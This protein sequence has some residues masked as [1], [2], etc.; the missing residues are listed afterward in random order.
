VTTGLTGTFFIGS[1]FV[2]FHNQPYYD[3]FSDHVPLGQPMLEFAESH[4]WD[5]LTTQQAIDST[6]NA[7]ISA[8]R[9]VV[10][11]INRTPSAHDAA[12][13]TRRAAEKGAEDVK[14]VAVDIF[15]K[16]KSRVESVGTHAKADVQKEAERIPQLIVVRPPKVS[17]DLA[18]L[19]EKVEH[20]LAGRLPTELASHVSKPITTPTEETS[21]AVKT[22]SAPQEPATRK[23]EGKHV[24]EAP[25][26]VG[27]EPPPGFS[28]PS[29]PKRATQEPAKPDTE[30]P[31]TLP[32][33]ASAVSSLHPSEPIINHLAGTIDNLASFVASNPTTASKVTDVLEA[34]KGDLTALADRIEKARDEERAVLEAKLDEQTREYSL[35]LMELEMAAQDKLD[36]QEDDFRKLFDAER[37][38]FVLSYRAKLEHELQ[39]QTEL[40]NE[41][42]VRNHTAFRLILIFCSLKEEVIAQGI[43][44]QR[45]WIRDIKVRVEQERGGRLAK[46]DELSSQ[47][48]RLERV[49]LDN[50]TYLDENIRIHAMWSAVRALTSSALASPV[51]NPFREELRVLRHVATAREDPIVAAALESLESSD[52]PDVGVEPF[53]DLSS[54]FTSAVAPKVCHVALVPDE[55]AGVL[56]HIASRIFS[57]LRFKRHGLVEGDDVLSVLARAEYHLNEKDLDSAARELNQLKGAAKVLL[58]DWLEAARRRLEVQ[59][60]LEVFRLVL[61]CRA[62]LIYLFRLFRLR[63]LWHHYLLYSPDNV[64]NRNY[65]R[66]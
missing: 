6:K 20:A 36:N 10:D 49:A 61:T 23:E 62:D 2:A 48:K 46:I 24:Y 59:Q 17:S 56:S 35:K 18:E 21:H 38:K 13:T 53:A 33:V 1:T 42:Y 31:M 15:K 29:P 26:P 39:T 5:T 7:I 19:V 32:L 27:F 44:L 63:Q 41:R 55:N 8:Q 9:F 51:R 64:H 58:Q 60:T 47:L 65:L 34:A 25:L 12:E 52:V 16:S 50:S 30:A 4:N 11:T 22:D 40:I 66:E 3:F 45:R 37:T 43:E 28:R 57:G 54:W 14:A